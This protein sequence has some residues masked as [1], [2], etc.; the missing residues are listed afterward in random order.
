MFH[1]KHSWILNICL[2]EQKEDQMRRKR[3]SLDHSSKNDFRKPP[4]ERGRF[5]RAILEQYDSLS[6]FAF[7]NDV[8]V[9]H[10]SQICN[11][12]VSP[13]PIRAERFARA[14]GGT[15]PEFFPELGDS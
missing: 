2:S 6:C 13:P 9:G 14:L 15:V 11:G 4:L 7:S 10:I 12:W 5:R 3:R 8:S 1:L